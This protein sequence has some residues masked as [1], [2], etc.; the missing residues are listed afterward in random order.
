MSEAVS[1]KALKASAVSA[2]DK[3]LSS[4]TDEEVLGEAAARMEGI[5]NRDPNAPR[6]IRDAIAAFLGSAQ[7]AGIIDMIMKKF[8]GGA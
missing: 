6:P 7:F 8:F 5:F 1:V 4:C 2:K 3:A